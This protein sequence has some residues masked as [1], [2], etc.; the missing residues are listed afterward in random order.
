M[1]S[2]E[3][4]SVTDEEGAHSNSKEV[5]MKE[6]DGETALDLTEEVTPSESTHSQHSGQPTSLFPGMP[7]G[8]SREADRRGSN[9]DSSPR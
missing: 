1:S 7:N 2:Y 3:Q 5:A 8:D 6:L 9:C 4:L